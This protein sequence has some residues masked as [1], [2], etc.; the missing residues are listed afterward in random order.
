[1]DFTFLIRLCTNI[2]LSDMVID[3]KVRQ[4]LVLELT[5]QLSTING[6]EEKMENSPYL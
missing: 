1:M 6:E 5:M 4:T 3:G 2:D